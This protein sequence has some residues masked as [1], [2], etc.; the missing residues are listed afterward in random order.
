MSSE[1]SLEENDVIGDINFPFLKS[2]IVYLF[3]LIDCFKFSIPFF[4]SMFGVADSLIKFS[5]GL[6]LPYFY[7]NIYFIGELCD[8]VL[9]LVIYLVLDF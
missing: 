4:N 8:L 9:G 3:I 2:F 6:F 7:I 5:E 1:L